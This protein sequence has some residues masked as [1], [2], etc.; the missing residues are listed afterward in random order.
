MLKSPLVSVVIPCYNHGKY[1]QETVESVMK[2][3]YTHY[4]IIIVDDESKDNSL[5]LAYNLSEKFSQIR[6]LN[7]KN[8]GPARARNH[9]IKE[10]EGE[11]ILPLDAD[12]LISSNYI[13]EGVKILLENPQIKV[14]YA[15]A[16]MFGAIEKEWKLKPFSHY[17]LAL[18]NM[19]YVSALFRKRD[20]EKVGGF[21]ESP[22]LVREDWE[23]WIKMLKSGGLAYQ[24]PFNGFFYRI[25]SNSRRKSM[26][27]DR[28]KKEIEYLNTHHKDFFDQQLSGK[29]REQ[30]TYSKAFNKVQKLFNNLFS[31][32]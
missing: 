16:R 18:D 2:S 30:R 6:V 12:D 5:D 28:K 27:N 14:V 29:L 20:W 17:N 24:M 21:T 3:S 11:I 25:H 4:E 9:G 8:S 19:I 13:E 32:K 23:F 31:N 10:A 26:N 7:Q 22:I 15:K 1:L